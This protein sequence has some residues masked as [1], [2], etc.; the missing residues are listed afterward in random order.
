MSEPSTTSAATSNSVEPLWLY[1][2]GSNIHG[3]VQKQVIIDKWIQGELSANSL[4]ARQG[5]DFAAL[6]QVAA[7][8]GHYEA[9]QDAING[10]VRRSAYRQLGAAMAILVLVVAGVCGGLY[11]SYQK[12]VIQETALAEKARLAAQKVQQQR[13][14]EQ[15]EAKRQAALAQVASSNLPLVALV[16]LGTEHDVHITQPAT[17]KQ[18]RN[19]SL[20]RRKKHARVASTTDDNEASPQSTSDEFV[21]TC[22]LSQQDIFSTLRDQLAKLNVCIQDEKRQ[23]TQHLLPPTLKLQFIVHASGHVS[24]LNVD[25]PHFHTGRLNNCLNKAFRTI[26]FKQT[27]GADCP[28]TIPIRIAH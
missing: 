22:Q 1:K 4:V 23:D 15:A 21:E 14:A 24:E 9:A 20:R 16:S 18:G 27:S 13:L 6:G 7:F 19:K 26:I 10:R 28:I 3:P 8:A 2:I 17:P 12:R 25:D 11:R 5:T